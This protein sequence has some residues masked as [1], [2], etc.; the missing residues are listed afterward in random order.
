M[1]MDTVLDIYLEMH[2]NPGGAW[3]VHALVEL[4]GYRI[5]YSP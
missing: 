3:Q 4:D 1:K 5:V 2:F